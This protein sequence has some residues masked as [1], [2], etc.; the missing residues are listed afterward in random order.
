MSEDLEPPLY[1]CPG[2]LGPNTPCHAIAMTVELQRRTA[3]LEALNQQIRQ[4]QASYRE[5]Y[6]FAPVGFATVDIG[7]HIMETNRRFA[8]LACAVSQSLL[9]ADFIDLFAIE[10]R[11]ALERCLT[12]VRMERELQI[13]EVQLPRAGSCVWVEV[14]IAPSQGTSSQLRCSIADI[15]HRKLADLELMAAKRDA[16]AASRAKTEFLATMSHEIRTPLHAVLGTSELLSATPLEDD[17]RELVATIQS[18]GDG[19]LHLINDILDF[20]RLDGRRVELE[21]AEIELRSTVEDAVSSMAVLTANR[22]IDLSCRIG[23]DV[24]NHVMGDGHRL[25]QV[26]V[27]LVGNAIKFTERGWVE[28]RVATVEMCSESAT[29]RF[30]VED[31]GIGI[32]RDRL[33]TLFDPFSQADSSVTRRFGGSGLGLAIT[34]QLVGLMGGALEVDSM[35]HHGSIFSFEV[36]L[37]IAR[38]ARDQPAG[39]NTIRRALVVDGFARSRAAITERLQALGTVVTTC[40]TGHVARR[41]A[42]S[43]LFDMVLVDA[44]LRDL[45]SSG[46]SKLIGLESGPELVFLR[47]P[48]RSSRT[49]LEQTE[50][51]VLTRPVASSRLRRL[52]YR[53]RQLTASKAPPPRGALDHTL[54]TRHPLKVLVVDDNLVSRKVLT[55]ML[56][57]MG[58]RPDTAADGI[59]AVESARDEAYDLIFMDMQ[60]PEL[61]GIEATRRILMR[62]RQ[63]PHPRIVAVTANVS[64]RDEAACL[65]AGMKGFVRKPFRAHELHKALEQTEPADLVC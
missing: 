2:D 17:Q 35:P 56:E 3:E 40:S 24:P 19:L 15:T 16:E 12:T 46:L 13:V 20:S 18:S 6:E 10:H 53:D 21:H 50:H 29:L 30:E 7:G 28:V 26:L 34:H 65:R 44:H 60:M 23:A 49:P 48:G 33:Q 42:T 58:Y 57:R 37:P 9:G 1:I 39:R 55:A 38:T 4:T 61:D 14:R 64:A 43:E 22:D 63:G 54:A 25:R 8:D 52:L 59:Q 31:T 51:E 27:N 62:A 36:M 5:L 47:W 32:P 45:T 11:R 41:L